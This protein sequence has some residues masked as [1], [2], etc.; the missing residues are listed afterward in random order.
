MQSEPRNSAPP[1]QATIKALLC[2]PLLLCSLYALTHWSALETLCEGTGDYSLLLLEIEKATRL[3]ALTGPYSRFH[4]RH[5]APSASYLLAAITKF[6]APTGSARGAASLAQLLVNSLLLCAAV[7]ALVRLRGQIIYS[8]AVFYLFISLFMTLRPEGLHDIWGP[9]QVVIPV[10]CFLCSAPLIIQR[11]LEWSFWFV[12]SAVLALS[13]HLGTVAIVAP[14]L[15]MCAL[16][17]PRTKI[18][19]R[20]KSILSTLSIVAAILCSL[21]ALTPPAIDALTNNGGNLRQL[22]TFLASSP[23]SE[24]A[25]GF[26]KAQTFLG[27]FISNPLGL[28]D[29]LGALLLLAL[30]I[31]VACKH[32]LHVS[33]ARVEAVVGL[34]ALL[35]AIFGAISIRGP[36]HQYL[37]FP[38]CAVVPLLTVLCM[39]GRRVLKIRPAKPALLGG[40]LVFTLCIAISFWL[41]KRWEAPQTEECSDSLQPFAA[42]F[43]ISKTELL[44][45]RPVSSESWQALASSVY[46][47][48][49]D[50]YR[51]CVPARWGFMMGEDL[52]CSYVKTASTSIRSF[53]VIDPKKRPGAMGPK[54]FKVGDIAWE[55][56]EA[57]ETEPLS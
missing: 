55:L 51:V 37:M 46:R 35:G 25:T 3:E 36:L 26:L 38:I 53:R 11:R 23:T 50:G 57:E 24:K 19:R 20:E 2:G 8:L 33:P 44:E 30:A 41:S 18:D 42:H 52:V 29:W 5:P 15:V 14:V 47:L 39:H 7:A 49:R 22:I 45:L 54:V 6:F 17:V 27:S 28:P 43:A 16:G 34:T 9:S 4:M 13:S 48:Y 31:I 56:G 40:T 10:F 12:A 21:A 32:V 1:I